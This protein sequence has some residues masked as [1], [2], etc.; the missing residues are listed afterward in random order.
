MTV[1]MI[2]RRIVTA[3]LWSA[4][5][6]L[7]LVGFTSSV[8]RTFGVFDSR[9]FSDG[10]VPE[11]SRID[12]E[13]LPR[14]AS[15][16]G[17]EPGTAA[18]REI[19]DQNRRFLGKYNQNPATTLLHVLPAAL[20]IVLA[21]LQ[22]SRGIRSRHIRWH[23][24]SGRLIVAIAIPVGLSG[25]WF[26]LRL[27]FAGAVE[28]SGVGLAGALFLFALVRAFSAIRNRDIAHHREWMMRMFA[29]ALGISTVRIAGTVLAVVTREG[30]ATWFGA[31][32]WI[33]FAVNVALAELWIRLT[34]GQPQSSA[35]V[36]KPS[37]ASLGM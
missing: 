30:P 29:V 37:L 5:V 36:V 33:G 2:N 23:R 6:L 10:P 35:G 16:L 13:S 34:R 1:R 27:P 28:A 21:P 9:A 19:E 14:I 22:F 8:A 3:A 15:L 12:R 7:A 18:Y 25:L 26:G 24:W 4:V 20:F 31:S 11:L 32:V 17:I